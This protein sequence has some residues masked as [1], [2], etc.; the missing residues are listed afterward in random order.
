MKSKGDELLN[1]GSG[2]LSKKKYQN[3]LEEYRNAAQIYQELH[4]EQFVYST[5]VE[6]GALFIKL[7]DPAA[8]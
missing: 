8:A 1:D 5:Y 4:V 7:H 2:E 6:L 3:A